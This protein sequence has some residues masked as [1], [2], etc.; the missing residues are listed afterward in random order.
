MSIMDF[1]WWAMENFKHE[2]FVNYFLGGKDWRQMES[3]QWEDVFR[4]LEFFQVKE[5]LDA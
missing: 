1:V 5:E 4:L 2:N 3:G